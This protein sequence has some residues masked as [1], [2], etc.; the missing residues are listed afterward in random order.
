MLKKVANIQKLHFQDVNIFN[1]YSTKTNSIKNN[2][3]QF[4][5]MRNFV[6]KAMNFR[7]QDGVIEQQLN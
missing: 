5:N 2:L 3:K 4:E 6:K 1:S 7:L